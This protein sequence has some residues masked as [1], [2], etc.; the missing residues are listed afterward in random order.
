M[1]SNTGGGGQGDGRKPGGRGGGPAGYGGGARGY[2]GGREGSGLGGRG[3]T[4]SGNKRQLGNDEYT[5]PG[6][7]I[8]NPQNE[9]PNRDVAAK[10]EKDRPRDNPSIYQTFGNDIS[11]PLRPGFGKLG[12]KI[13]LRT[14]HFALT[15]VAGKT[16]YRY[17]VN[18]SDPEIPPGRKRRQFFSN[19][20]REI[21][22]LQNMRSRVATDYSSTLITAGKIDFESFADKMSEVKLVEEKPSE[23]ESAKDILYEET[24]TAA[25]SM[26]K[27]SDEEEFY[28]KYHEEGA[29][30]RSIEKASRVTISLVGLVPTSEL[31]NYLRSTPEDST[32]LES[33]LTTI[34]ALN[35]VVNA[36][37]NQEDAIYQASRNI[38]AAYPRNSNPMEMTVYENVNL[39]GGLIGVR[40][41]YSS[42]KT[43]TARLLLNLHG[44]CSAFYP[45]LNLL[46]LIELFE[47]SGKSWSAI[48]RFV[49]RLRVRFNYIKK[50]GRIIET[51]KT[52]CGFYHQRG[53]KYGSSQSVLFEC[54][55][56]PSDISV[57][58][59]FKRKHG[60]ALKFPTKPVINFGSEQN[61]VWIPAELGTVMPGQTF[62]GDLD[63]KQTQKMLEMAARGPAEN[64]R[65]LVDAGLK[66]IGVEKQNPILLAF[67][68]SIDTKMIVVPARI[69]Q[70]PDLLYNDMKSFKPQNASWNLVGRKFYKPQRLQNWSY[71]VC[72]RGTF[73]KHHL[74]VLRQQIT[75]C[76][77]GKDDPNPVA[78]YY[79]TLGVSDDDKTDE[80]LQ[81]ALQRAKTAG[82]RFLFVILETR[83]KPI[84]ARLKFFADVVVGIQHTTF[85]LSKLAQQFSLRK[86]N[87]GVDYFA[88]IMQKVNVK[89]GGIN[90]VIASQSL[91]FVQPQTTMLVGVDVSHQRSMTMAEAPSVVGIVASLDDNF[92]KWYGTTCVQKGGVE[93]VEKIGELMGERLSLYGR[94]Y[95]KYPENII[96][97]RDGVSEG[98]FELVVKHEVLAIEAVCAK[99][100]SDKR[101]NPPKLVVII[102][103]KR[104]RT[105]FYPTKEDDADRMNQNTKNGTVVDR[106]VT[107]EKF[108]DFFVQPHAAI[109]GTAK[110]CHC[111]VIRD[112]WKLPA[113]VLQTITHNLSYLYGRATK[114]VSLCTPAYYADIMCERGNKYL[115]KHLHREWPK[116]TIFDADTNP[117]PWK[118]DVHP[119]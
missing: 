107:S 20:L 17:H 36:T 41:Y 28:L 109:K 43:S 89:I 87:P 79:T 54:S 34:Q 9:I 37:P 67:G 39:T 61:P 32:H 57:A 65:S 74:E 35:I 102:C 118:R 117:S 6:W 50:D 99:K 103:G 42:A 69:L 58:D 5:K 105:R 48:E 72:G 96:I 115:A 85:V 19:L 33:R 77:L 59:Y 7:N 95:K 100:Y 26:G 75:A 104:H 112:D 91:P 106:G 56:Y 52:V 15:L 4:G 40:S 73:A 1:F 92:T 22:A 116:G 55:D 62:R 23:D 13:N 49:R 119:E 2:G 93:M 94:T 98:Q 64:A 60:I 84:H 11:L 114:A 90:H 16:M 82:V 108:W 3:T 101:Q 81:N 14:N 53:G 31:A 83:S 70:A 113:D 38:F 97:Y 88:N 25:K 68:I 110:P 18:T 45:E 27:K 46:K 8:F 30:P 78:G 66:V 86:T 12:G 111:T 71:L 51:I 24:S 76:G 47:A 21:P 44:Q 29:P 80:A 63:E 10:E